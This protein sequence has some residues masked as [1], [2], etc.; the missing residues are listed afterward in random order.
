MLEHEPLAAESSMEEVKE[1][2]GKLANEK[3][4]RTDD[5]CG[6]LFKLGRN[7][8]SAI[9]KRLHI[10]VLTVWRQEEVAQDWKNIIICH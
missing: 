2:V 7:E 1:A 10:T 3:A 9:L 5:I 8:D 4:V 6:R